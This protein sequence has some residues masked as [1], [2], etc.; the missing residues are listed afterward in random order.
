MDGMFNSA[1]VTVM[2]SDMGRAVHFYKEILGLKLVNR[3]GNEW[4]QIQGPGIT[5]GL[6]PQ[7]EERKSPEEGNVSIGFAVESLE[8]AMQQLKKKG[9]DFIEHDDGHI[10]LALFN[11]SDGTPLYLGEVKKF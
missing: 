9:I 11:D 5:I 3:F 7:R 1:N 8:K 6:H 2:V 10:R 4:A